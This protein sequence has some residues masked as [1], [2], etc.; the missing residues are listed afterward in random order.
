MISLLKSPSD[1]PASNPLSQQSLYRGANKGYNF[2][3]IQGRVQDPAKPN[4]EPSIPLNWVIATDDFSVQYGKS[5]SFNVV[6]GRPVTFVVILDIAKLFD[7]LY[8]ITTP[9]IK[10]DPGDASD[11]GNATTLYNNFKDKAYNLQL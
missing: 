10:C 9:I 7:G 11:F 4:S 1:F 6:A 3:T 5:Q 8:P 2:V